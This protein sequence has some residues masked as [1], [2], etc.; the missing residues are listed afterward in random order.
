[1][2]TVICQ[3]PKCGKIFKVAN[4]FA[5]RRKYCPECNKDMH[6]KRCRDYYRAHKDEKKDPKK[7][8]LC[9][10]GCGRPVG[11]GLHF[12]SEYCFKTKQNDDVDEYADWSSRQ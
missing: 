7:I 9:S 5:A 6:R 10:C 4:H 8:K 3:N 1:M 12:L 2:L 11:E